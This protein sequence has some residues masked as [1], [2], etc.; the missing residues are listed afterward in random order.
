MLAPPLK[1]KSLSPSVIWILDIRTGMFS[2]LSNNTFECFGY[3]HQCLMDAGYYL[4]EKNKHPDDRNGFIRQLLRESNRYFSTFLRQN[5]LNHTEE[6]KIIKPDLGIVKIREQCAVYK[7]NYL[8]FITH[9]I[10]SSICITDVS[11]ERTTKK[12]E[13]IAL[14]PTEG[15]GRLSRRELEIIRLISEGKSSKTIANQLFISF[16]TVVTHRKKINEKI[17]VKNSGELIRYAICNGLI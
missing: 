10:G 17:R 7:T 9:L 15:Y 1:R 11:N 12:K 5:D 16:H 14:K 13:D 2:Y 6:Y 3:Q 4:I 8:G